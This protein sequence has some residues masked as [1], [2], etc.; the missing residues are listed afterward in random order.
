MDAHQL[1]EFHVRALFTHDRNMRLRKVNEPWAGEA[2]APRF[3]L[4][5][6]IEG[7]ALCRLRYDVPEGIVEQLAELCADEPAVWDFQA[8]P[9]H[10]D[11]YMNLLQGERFSMGPCFVIP[12]EAAPIERVVRIT[13]ENC[14][15]FRLDGF[16]WLAQEIDCVQPCVALVD[17]GRV[18]SVCRS[19]RIT[20]EAHEAGLETIEAY[21]GRGYAAGVVAGWAA[22]VRAGGVL[23]LY[24]TSWDNLASQSVARKAGLIFYGVNFIIT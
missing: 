6:T 4:G 9:K 1:M 24:S 8:K 7:T 21:R 20:P 10:F 13:E 19:V 14:S 2:P 22:A 16:E 23:P 17:E 18:V 11:E 3:F 15:E 12:E 5:R